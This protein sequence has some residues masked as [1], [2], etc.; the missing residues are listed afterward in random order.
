MELFKLKKA[1]KCEFTPYFKIDEQPLSIEEQ[2]VKTASD[3]KYIEKKVNS[4][5]D[6]FHG[7]PFNTAPMEYIRKLLCL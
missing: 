6:K 1:K 4:K 2:Q 7:V 5:I 3:L